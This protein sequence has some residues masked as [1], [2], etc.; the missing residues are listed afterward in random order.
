MRLATADAGTRRGNI[1]IRDRGRGGS[2]TVRVLLHVLEPMVPRLLVSPTALDFGTQPPGASHKL[3]LRITNGGPGRL[4]WEVA[5]APPQLVL[6]RHEQGLTVELASDF[7]GDLSGM[8]RLTSNGGGADVR[9]KGTAVEPPSAPPLLT[10]SAP[11]APDPILPLLL[12]WWVNDA[13]ALHIQ[14]HDGALVYTD[15]N[16]LGVKVGQ[17][18]MQVQ[19]GTIFIQ[20]ANTFS[21][22]YTGQFTL[23]GPLLTGMLMVVGQTVAVSFQRQQPWFAAFVN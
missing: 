22:G 16:L 17:G 21:G 6:N 2:R 11:L 12:G 7:V 8:L 3:E 13:G 10:P 9:V 5:E 19:H 18:T 1:F 14:Q 23:Q 20:G 4:Q 15:H